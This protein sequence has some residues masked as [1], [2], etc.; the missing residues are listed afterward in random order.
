MHIGH[1]IP[2]IFTKWLQDV[3]KVNVY[4]EVTDDEKFLQKAGYTLEET[5]EWAK[6]NILDIAAVGFDP[7]R[8]FIFP[9]YRI[10]QEHVPPGGK[11]WRRNSR[12]MRSGRPSDSTSPPT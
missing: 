6:D 12:S 2:F 5:R 11:K 8:T 4:I 9:R 1:L 10:H 3:F 7:D